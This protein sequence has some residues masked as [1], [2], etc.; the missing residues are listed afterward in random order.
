MKFQ[1]ATF[2]ETER[3]EI[4]RPGSRTPAD[5]DRKRDHR[6]RLRP[7]SGP[8]LIA[9]VIG[10]AVGVT[11]LTYYARSGSSGSSQAEARG[12]NAGPA[13]AD[14]DASQ[15]S[16]AIPFAGPA[17]AAGSAGMSGVTD[18][19]MR[20]GMVAPFTGPSKE[21]GR[22]MSL[23]LNAA[24]AQANETGG[25]AGRRIKLITEDDGYEPARTASAVAKLRDTDHVMGYVGNVGTP[26]AAVALPYALQNHMLFFGAFTG[27]E[28]LRTTPPDRYVFNYRPSYAE[29]TEAAVR[30]LV[31]VRG[32]RPQEI[33]VFAQA[34]S[35]GDSGFNGVLKAL[36]GLGSP[37]ANA[38]LRLNYVR[39]SLD[40]TAAMNGLHTRQH[41]VKAVVMVASYRAAAKFIETVRPEFPNLLFTNVSFVGSTALADELKLLGPTYMDH[42]I[43]TQTVPALNGYSNIALE[44]RA[45]LGK[46]F[47]GEA[48]D[49][50]SFEAYV[51]GK[52]LIEGLRKTGRNL[53]TEALVSSLENTRGLELGLGS[54]VSFGPSE[55]QASHKIWGTQ[56]ETTGGYSAIDID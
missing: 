6:M 54:P 43:V 55:H 18:G 49:Y 16:A 25:V 5:M 21:L 37:N 32:I 48:P 34:D 15:S 7:P 9:V 31:R 38:T 11:G 23:G 17:K 14:G 13:V 24:F 4:L 27:A 42:V 33:A 53:T 52:L 2:T 26:T 40:L 46:Y 45:A 47:P 20:F 50:V 36:R 1:R 3:P 12:R 10:L 35:F 29:E 44:Y 56:L 41:R 28:S 8:G 30:Y 39:N 51:D 22:E 19:E